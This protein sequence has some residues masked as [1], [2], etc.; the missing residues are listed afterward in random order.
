MTVPL[1]FRRRAAFAAARRSGQIT[2]A[3]I[4]KAGSSPKRQALL[5]KRK[6]GNR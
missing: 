5:H 1:G 4:A 3:E 2:Q 6:G